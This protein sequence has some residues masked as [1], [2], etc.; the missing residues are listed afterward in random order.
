MYKQTTQRIQS[1]K[2]RE[3]TSPR[4]PHTSTQRPLKP[5]LTPHAKP[6][7]KHPPRINLLLNLQQPLIIP[8]KEALPPILLELIR[9]IIIRRRPNRQRRIPHILPLQRN[10]LRRDSMDRSANRHIHER[11]GVAPDGVD[12]RRVGI[13]VA[14]RGADGVLP[15][16]G[17]LRGEVGDVVLDALA[18][19][20]VGHVGVCHDAA[21]VED[22][23]AAGRAARDERPEG[24]PV[25][26][27]PLLFGPGLRR[28]G[29]AGDGEGGG[30]GGE[31]CVAGDGGAELGG[32]RYEHDA[33][34]L[35]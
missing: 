30:P 33:V 2:K 22:V 35:G 11:K 9:L 16:E 27:V 10:L 21:G 8:T 12:G 24:A 31:G 1:R 26:V 7:I 23:G 19:C 14:R 20:G 3:E 28:G 13:D 15:Q 29:A 34:G 17:R 6:T 5:L 25:D 4:K 32:E 18:G